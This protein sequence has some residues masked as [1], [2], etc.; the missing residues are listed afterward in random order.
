VS[1]DRAA[2]EAVAAGDAAAFAA[3]IAATGPRL[4]RLAARMLGSL[5]EAEDAL[6]DAYIRAYDALRAGRFDGRASLD[7]WLYRI[8]ANTALDALRARRRRARWGL[9]T[10]GAGAPGALVEPAEPPEQVSSAERIAARDALRELSAW[11]DELPPD[12]RTALVLKEIEGLPT[13]EVASIMGS[14]VGAVE[15]RLVRARATLR[16]RSAGD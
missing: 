10:L 15:Q 9:F 7:T 16:K 11:I 3:V 13:G 12:Q 4:F 1:G 5:E 6:Q 2:I 8:V 14:S